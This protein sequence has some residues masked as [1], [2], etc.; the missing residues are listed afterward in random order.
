MQHSCGRIERKRTVGFHLRSVPPAADRPADIDHVVGEVLTETGVGENRLALGIRLCLQVPHHLELQ[1]RKAG[2][3]VGVK[4]S[5]VEIQSF[6]R[7]GGGSVRRGKE[8]SGSRL[9]L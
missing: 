1:G 3:G 2:V 7:G 4:K 5:H 6:M 9:R 8:P